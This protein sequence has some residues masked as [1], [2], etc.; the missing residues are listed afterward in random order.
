MHPKLKRMEMKHD[1]DTPKFVTFG[2]AKIETLTV[3]KTVAWTNA[4]TI[5]AEDLEQKSN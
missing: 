5:N 2:T 1:V 3:N 4:M